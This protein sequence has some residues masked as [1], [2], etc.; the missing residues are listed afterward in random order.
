M[1]VSGLPEKNPNHA[2]E[3]VGKFFNSIMNKFS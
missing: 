1:V 3:I 2:S